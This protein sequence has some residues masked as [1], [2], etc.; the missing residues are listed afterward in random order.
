MSSS[1]TERSGAKQPP[2]VLC[3]RFMLLPEIRSG[4]MG[5]V[6]KAL[7]LQTSQFVAIKRM[8]SSG[9]Q[10]RL[11][12]SFQREVEALQRLDHTN[13]VTLI[14]VDQDEDGRWFLAMEW[15]E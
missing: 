4:G 14:S 13:I 3:D 6:Q 11:T 10:L 7:D 12:T 15:I 8:K 9:D 5:E 1:S 2:Q